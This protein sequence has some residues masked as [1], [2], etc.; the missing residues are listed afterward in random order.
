MRRHP[1]RKLSRTHRAWGPSEGVHGEAERLMPALVAEMRDD[2]RSD[3]AELMRNVVVLLSEG[4]IF[5]GGPIPAHA[6]IR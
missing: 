6:G 4:V 2:V 3:T 1:P 5:T